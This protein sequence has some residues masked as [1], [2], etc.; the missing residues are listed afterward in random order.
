MKIHLI[1]IILRLQ[2]TTV[3][4]DRKKN[5]LEYFCRF[6]ISALILWN[7]YIYLFQALFGFWEF[8]AEFCGFWKLGVRLFSATL[9]LQFVKDVRVL[10]WE[11]CLNYNQLITNIFSTQIVAAIKKIRTRKEDQTV[12][13]FWRRLLKNQL[14]N[15][16]WKIFNKHCNI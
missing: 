11:K 2:V 14:Q 8:L 4:A 7:T 12:I 10:H 5:Y 6:V 15:L 9:N 1:E 3:Q 16:H 13:R